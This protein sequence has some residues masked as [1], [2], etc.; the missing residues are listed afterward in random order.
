MALLNPSIF[1]FNDPIT[2][3][4]H[5]GI[6]ANFSIPP[7]DAIIYD[8]TY[9]PT[10]ADKLGA[11]HLIL[12]SIYDNT[13]YIREYTFLMI[14]LQCQHILTY[15]IHLIQILLTQWLTWTWTSSHIYSNH[16]MSIQNMGK[17]YLTQLNRILN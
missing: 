17:V 12:D 2:W 6:F 11:I 8:A 14:F 4:L 7:A 16:L 13:T 3:I 1:F 15:L 5:A 10:K 9:V